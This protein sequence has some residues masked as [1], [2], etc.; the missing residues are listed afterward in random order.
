MSVRVDEQLAVLTRSD[1][2]FGIG[3][4]RALAERGLRPALIG[5]EDTPFS[6]RW[7]MFR[8]LGRRI[9]HLDAARYQR[10]FWS[11]V[12]KRAVSGGRWRPLHS[13]EGLADRVVR[14]SSINDPTIVDSIRDAGITKIV[15]AQSGIVRDGILGIPG[16]WVVNAHPAVLP[17]YRGVD[18]VRWTLLDGGPLGAT[19]HVV[20][21]GVDTGGV[22]ARRSLSVGETDHWS[23]LEHRAAE[24]CRDLLLE[25]A[26]SGPDGFPMPEPQSS[27]SGKQYYLMPFRTAATLESQWNTIRENYLK[28][29][30]TPSIEADSS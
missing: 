20:D 6:K 19:M 7:R 23:D 27:A 5:L 2:G 15:L 22:I 14:A 18:V 12:V 4:L 26:L 28:A 21:R 9:G 8:R 11:P 17:D 3:F 29:Q 25:A 30:R 10:K 16:V 13:Y 24:A 1:S